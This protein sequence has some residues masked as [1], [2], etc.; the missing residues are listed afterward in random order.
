VGRFGRFAGTGT[1]PLVTGLAVGAAQRAYALLGDGTRYRLWASADLASWTELALPAT[2]PVGGQRL[3]S[4]T[5][6]GGRLLLAAEDG[7][8]T[9]VWTAAG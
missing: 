5:G 7:S 2:V 3:V 6:T 4:L 8:A 1:A 9:R